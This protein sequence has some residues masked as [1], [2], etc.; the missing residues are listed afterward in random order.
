M[1][2]SADF[3][4]WN[5]WLYRWHDASGAVEAFEPNGN[6]R[7]FPD[8]KSFERALLEGPAMKVPGRRIKWW[9]I[10]D[11]C[12]FLVFAYY[13]IT[14]IVINAPP[15]PTTV[16]ETVTRATLVP[17][18]ERQF[19]DVIN[20]ATSDYSSLSKQEEVARQQRNGIVEDRL[21][22]TK[23]DVFHT[24]NE[25]V[26]KLVSANGFKLDNWVFVISR[27]SGPYTPD[28]NLPMKWLPNYVA[29]DA[30]PMCS[31]NT[32][33]EARVVAT[34]EIVDFLSSKKKG[35]QIVMSGQFLQRFGGERD[36]ASPPV[37]TLSTVSSEKFEGSLTEKGSMSE[38]E[39][40]IYVPSLTGR[41]P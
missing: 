4:V 41:N 20:K 31:A 11:L 9:H 15:P 40:K 37:A 32:Q 7:I 6:R 18:Q 5:G 1:T 16:T 17:D 27:I 3:Q 36:A 30:T 22:R 24:R 29:I 14:H 39:Y 26:F 34:Q 8:W 10:F 12:A 13:F 23:T 25:D 38:P 35:D 33:I 19:C 21:S 28:N 2:R